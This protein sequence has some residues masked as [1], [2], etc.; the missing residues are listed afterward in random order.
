MFA[1]HPQSYPFLPSF[2]FFTFFK[3]SL[4]MNRE[5]Q[6]NHPTALVR[7]LGLD[8]HF[9]PNT[10]CAFIRSSLSFLFCPLGSILYPLL[11]FLPPFMSNF[12][13]RLR[14]QPISVLFFFLTNLAGMGLAFQ[15][16]IG[17]SNIDLVISFDLSLSVSFY[18]QPVKRLKCLP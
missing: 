6:R 17:N 9:C 5:T 15:L 1:V 3:S 10:S 13:S 16:I 8:H 4:V 14:D 18:Y 7:L 2:G 12:K 11:E